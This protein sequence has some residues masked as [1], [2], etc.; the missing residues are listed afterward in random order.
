PERFD[1]FDEEWEFLSEKVIQGHFSPI[2]DMVEEFGFINKTEL[3]LSL[4]STGNKPDSLSEQSWKDICMLTRR[5][6]QNGTLM[7]EDVTPFLYCIDQ[8]QGVEIFSHIRYLFI[9]EAQ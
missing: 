6:I 2:E 9:D 4:F 1:D 7:W 3:Y 5:S 8:I